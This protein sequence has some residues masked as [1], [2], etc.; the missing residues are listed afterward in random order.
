[1]LFSRNQT[2]PG[3]TGGTRDS[4]GLRW[5]EV[6]KDPRRDDGQSR[7]TGTIVLKVLGVGTVHGRI[8]PLRERLPSNI[9]EAHVTI[10]RDRF[11]PSVEVF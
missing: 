6:K 11:S 7:P 8:A 9:V 2:Q 5:E 10:P 1:M 3:R 4:I